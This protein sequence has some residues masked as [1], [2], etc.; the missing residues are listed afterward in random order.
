MNGRER[1]RVGLGKP[2]R[3]SKVPFGHRAACI[4]RGASRGDSHQVVGGIDI[5]YRILPAPAASGQTADPSTTGD[6]APVGEY[7]VIVALYYPGGK[8]MTDAQVWATVGEPDKAG[9]RKKLPP[10][11][12]GDT[13]SFDNCFVLG[14]SGPF[15]IAVEVQVRGAATPIEAVFEYR[16]R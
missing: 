5:H 10:A 6:D 15:R 8:R 16:G 4:R 9:V 3:R 7:H 1:K 12:T 13:R 11:R 14:G 2:R